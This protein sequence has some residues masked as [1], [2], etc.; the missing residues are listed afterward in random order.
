MGVYSEKDQVNPAVK[1]SLVTCV[2]SVLRMAR[3]QRFLRLKSGKGSEE[4]QR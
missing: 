2:Y 3:I 1:R 4:M